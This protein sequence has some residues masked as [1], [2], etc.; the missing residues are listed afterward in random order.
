ME[1]ELETL[2]AFVAESLAPSK[3]IKTSIPG[4][5]GDWT[6][7]CESLMSFSDSFVS[8][9]MMM[10]ILRVDDRDCCPCLLGDELDTAF[11]I[12]RCSHHPFDVQ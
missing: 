4:N 1:N 8:S 7:G 3:S 10:M 11:E 2:M 5:R 6:Q 12:T 9:L